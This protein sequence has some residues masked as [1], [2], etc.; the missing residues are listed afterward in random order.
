MKMYFYRGALPNFGDELNTWLLPKVFPNLFDEE[1]EKMFLGIGSIL[2]NDHPKDYLKVVFGSG[3]G[4]YTDIPKFDD[5]W[6]VYCVRGPRTARLC[7]FEP[8]K[9][10]GDAAILIAK[11]RDPT[12][13]REGCA[14]MPHW[15]SLE[16]GNW[17]AACELSGIRLIDPTKPVDDVLEDISRSE[18]IITESLHGAIV[19]DAMRVPWVAALPLHVSHRMKW[20]DWAE[21]LDMT[22]THHPIWPSSTREA[23]SAQTQAAAVR[24]K[25]PRGISKITIQMLD[26]GFIRLAASRLSEI[27]KQEAA[28]SSDVAFDRAL[29]RLELNAAQIMRDYPNG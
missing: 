28:L 9:V 18:M 16:K 6:R 4:G 13:K 25:N 1:N 14:F 23:R 22:V 29:S 27:K 26:W 12:K 7:N 5:S 21:A 24:L 15:E 2:F 3:Y 19:A 10:A 20:F 11:Y 17:A 8:Q